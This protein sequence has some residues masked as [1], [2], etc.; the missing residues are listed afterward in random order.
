MKILIIIIC[1][2]ILWI[3]YEIHTAPFIKEDQE[4]EDYE[5][6]EDAMF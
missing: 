5:S 1:I 6:D 2:S 3:M 4:L